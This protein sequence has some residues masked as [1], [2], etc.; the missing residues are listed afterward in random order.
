MGGGEVQGESGE[1]QQLYHGPQTAL[2]HELS[3]MILGGVVGEDG[4]KEAN[5]RVDKGI[6]IHSVLHKI[7]KYHYKAYIKSAVPHTL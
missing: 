2:L 7:V 4:I 5:L 3:H 6:I 1:G